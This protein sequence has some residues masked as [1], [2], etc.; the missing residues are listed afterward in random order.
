MHTLCIVSPGSCGVRNGLSQLVS[1]LCMYYM[2]MYMYMSAH[3]NILCV[4]S[5]LSPLSP[6]LSL[7]ISLTHLPHSWKCSMTQVLGMPTLLRLAPPTPHFTPHT[8]HLTLHTPHTPH[9]TLHTPHTS[10][11]TLHTPPLHTNMGVQECQEVWEVAV[12]LCDILLG[13]Y[14]DQMLSME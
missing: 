5:M 3:M 10:H 14:Q 12:S 8:P 4:C 2:Y 9:L 6:P 13:G 11:S 7:S 1:A